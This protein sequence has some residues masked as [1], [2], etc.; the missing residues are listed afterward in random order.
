MGV[1]LG[2]IDA[3]ISPVANSVFTENLPL[4]KYHSR[5]FGL[6]SLAAPVF[7]LFSSR[8]LWMAESLPNMYSFYSDNFAYFSF[9]F[10]SSKKSAFS[11]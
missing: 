6:G 3:M 2:F 8:G 5:F 7:T 10:Y 9:S 11:I 1:G 4:P